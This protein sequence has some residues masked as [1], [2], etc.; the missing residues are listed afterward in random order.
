MRSSLARQLQAPELPPSPVI[1]MLTSEITTHRRVPAIFQLRC[2]GPGCAHYQVNS[3]CCTNRGADPRTGSPRWACSANLP[4]NLKLECVR[5]DCEGYSNSD[6]EFV[7]EGSC[8]V[9]NGVGF[10]S[11]GQAAWNGREIVSD[12]E[13]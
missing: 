11:E 9:T 7:L 4:R 5:V 8:G 1:R 12:R 2:L 6:D 13:F 3:M 10:T